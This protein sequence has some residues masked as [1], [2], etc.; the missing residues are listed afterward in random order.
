MALFC[1]RLKRCCF[2]KGN[3]E[4]GNRIRKVES[5]NEKKT[6]QIIHLLGGLPVYEGKCKSLKNKGTPKHSGN[7]PHTK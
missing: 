1:I 5:T 4:K 7:Q 2:K 3:K 6:K